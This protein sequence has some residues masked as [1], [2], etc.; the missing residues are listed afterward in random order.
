MNK[1]SPKFKVLDGP[2]RQTGSTDRFVA[3]AS[4]VGNG[5]INIL[6][7]DDESQNLTVLEALLDEPDYQLVRAQSADQ[8]LL[9]LL[10]KEFAVLILDIRMP[11]VTGFELA[12]MIKERKK[13]SRVPI[14]FLTAY[15]NEDQHV[16]EGYG[17]GAVDYLVKPVN[18]TILRSKV[19]V[20]AELYRKQREVESANRA[21][22]A[23]VTE[24]RRAEAELHELNAT[25]E[26]RVMERT[27]ALHLSGERLRLAV[28]A[29]QTGLWDYNFLTGDASWSEEAWTVFGRKPGAFTI[30][31][32]TWLDFVHPADRGRVM[33]AYEAARNKGPYRDEFRVLDLDG[34]VRW[35]E[36]RGEFLLDDA[37]RPVRFSGSVMDITGRKRT[38]AQMQLLLR[39]VNHRAKNML[40]LVEAVARR[41]AAEDIGKYLQYFCER[42]Q[43]L[44]ASQDLLVE[45]EWKGVDIDALVRAQMALFADLFDT[46]IRAHGPS[47]VLSPGAAQAIGMALHE[48]ATNA[49]K[50]GALSNAQGH[51]EITWELVKD[52]SSDQNVAISWIERDGP[53]VKAPVRRGFGSTV[54]CDAIEMELDAEVRL[55]YASTGM[56]WHVQCPA[57]VVLGED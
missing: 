14:I 10:D 27:E 50:Y 32:E 12:Q 54:I 30:T 46:R 40:G 29:A 45:S 3:P 36:A 57:A 18:P 41:T 6:L 37:G 31:H 48:L 4:T 15:Y 26:R 28:N 23:E 38:E 51:V 33:A 55:N 1:N 21:L 25:L 2:L 11:G 17:T 34:G 39:E 24:R 49:C 53:P 20:Y 13:T 8:A 19:A 56:E 35:V 43:A 42:I 47:L 7:V 44:S 52:G 16:L 22:L 5:K 9:E